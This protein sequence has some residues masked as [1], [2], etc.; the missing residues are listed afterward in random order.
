MG[1]PI[2]ND[3]PCSWFGK[4]R[5]QK[6]FCRTPLLARGE[7]GKSPRSAEDVQ[8]PSVVGLRRAG[9]WPASPLASTGVR[10]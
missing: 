3:I 8:H 6:R 5:A 1:G 4:F 9:L 2:S 7:A 10:Q